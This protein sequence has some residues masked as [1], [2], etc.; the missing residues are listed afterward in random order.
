VLAAELEALL[1]WHRGKRD[2]AVA[3]L[4]DLANEED[5]FAAEYGPPDIVKPTHELLGE[6]LLELKRPA[7][8]QAQFVRALELAPG[9]SPALLG[10]VRAARAAGDRAAADRALAELDR[11]WKEA[12]A[13]LPALAELKQ[14]R[15]ER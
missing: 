13:G 6:L 3:R 10:L 5:S 1:L 7:E 8:A 9:R 15:A 2:E 12:D 11:N 14:V 4:R